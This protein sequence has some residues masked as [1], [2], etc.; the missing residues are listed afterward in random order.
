MDTATKKQERDRK[1]IERSNRPTRYGTRKG[2]R[3][4]ARAGFACLALLWADAAVSWALAPSDAAMYTNLAAILI[5]FPVGFWVFGNLVPATRG[6]V[7]LAEHLLDERQVSERLRAHAIAHRL[8]LGLLVVV[9]ATVMSAMPG[10]GRASHV[11]GAAVLLLFFALLFSVALL[12]YLI[13]AWR[14]PDS[15]PEDEE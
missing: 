12:P 13:I 14:L 3:M 7:G 10:E 15:P 8:G 11:A 5:A 1:A 2:R 9:F 4:L 6:T